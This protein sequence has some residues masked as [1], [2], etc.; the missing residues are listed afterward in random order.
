MEVVTLDYSF[1]F[2][3]WGVPKFMIAVAAARDSLSAQQAEDLRIAVR[4]SPE[5]CGDGLKVF[6]S[7]LFVRF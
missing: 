5:K 1:E 7:D 6:P 3:A 4:D 2:I